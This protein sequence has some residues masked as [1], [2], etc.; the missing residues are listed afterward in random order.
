MSSDAL[1]DIRGFLVSSS[2]VTSIVPKKDISVG[3]RKTIDNFPCIILNQIGGMDKGYLGYCTTPTGTRN[4]EE[5]Y[6]FTVDIYSRTNRKQTYTIADSVVPLLIASGSCTKVND[7][8]LY[9]DNLSVYRKL[10]TYKY[11]KFHQD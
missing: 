9:D 11:T 6:I 10:Q 7:I 4:R 1:T 3:W 2:S 8:D 5:L